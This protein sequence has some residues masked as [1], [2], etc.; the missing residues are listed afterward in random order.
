[1]E[2]ILVKGARGRSRDDE[3]DAR[4]RGGESNK[5][6]IEK[7]CSRRLKTRHSSL[8]HTYAHAYVTKHLSISTRSSWPNFFGFYLL[9]WGRA[10]DT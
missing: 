2:W 9:R 10:Q 1:M 7:H 3:K 4:R 5:G 6:S 8:L